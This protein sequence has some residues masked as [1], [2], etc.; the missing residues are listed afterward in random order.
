MYIIL[1]KDF[2]GF[3]CD[4]Y[5]IIDFKGIRYTNN[6]YI[7]NEVVEHNK[8][9]IYEPL[10]DEWEEINFIDNFNSFYDKEV[11][12]VSTFIYNYEDSNIIIY[13]K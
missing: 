9:A 7:S 4:V 6:N 13:L 10:I 2:I 3:I 12:G 11:I 1:F 5:F 8:R